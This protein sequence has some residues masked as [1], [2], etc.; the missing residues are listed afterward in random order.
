[1][2]LKRQGRLVRVLC[3]PLSAVWELVIWLIFIFAMSENRWVMVLFPRS[4]D[5]IVRACNALPR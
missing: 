2:D 5:L 1:M 4:D 3:I